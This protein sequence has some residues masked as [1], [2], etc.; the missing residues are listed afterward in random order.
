MALCLSP[1]NSFTQLNFASL[2]HLRLNAHLPIAHLNCKRRESQCNTSSITITS[3]WKQTDAVDNP[4]LKAWWDVH[5]TE[6]KINFHFM[7]TQMCYT[8]HLSHCY[9]QLLVVNAQNFPA[10]SFN[11]SEK[12]YGINKLLNFKDFSR[13]NKEIKY[14]SRTLT[15]FKDF[16]RRL[17]KFKTFSRLYEPCKRYL[18]DF[19]D[20]F[21]ISRSYESN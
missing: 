17:L 18:V 9:R 14:F 3:P 20:W 19:W 15:E 2:N 7:Y 4:T 10:K 11:F 8:D 21:G 6:A 16:S 12:W 13:P 1:L 5:E